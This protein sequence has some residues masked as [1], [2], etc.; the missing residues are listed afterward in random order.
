MV[1]RELH[2]I[3]LQN[4]MPSHCCTASGC[5]GGSNSM[6]GRDTDR[7]MLSKRSKTRQKRVFN[8]LI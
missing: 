7:A 1:G 2:M 8:I 5:T 3:P 6:D 4:V